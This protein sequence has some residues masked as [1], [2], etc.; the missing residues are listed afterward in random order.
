[1]QAFNPPPERQVQRLRLRW[2][3]AL[4]PPAELTWRSRAEDALRTASTAERSRVVFVRRLA[5][6]LPA[7]AA[8]PEAMAARAMHAPL[9][10]ALQAAVE[11]AVPAALADPGRAAA[12]WFADWDAALAHLLDHW[13]D[14]TGAAAAG[15]PVQPS[16]AATRTDW[17][18]AAIAR[19]LPGWLA[20]DDAAMAPGSAVAPRVAAVWC[21]WLHTPA[22][23]LAAAAW[24]LGRWRA[25]A[26]RQVPWLQQAH[27]RLGTPGPSAAAQRAGAAAVAPIVAMLQHM[28]AQR[29]PDWRVAVAG[30]A[31]SPPQPEV[32]QRATASGPGRPGLPAPRRA[33]LRFDADGNADDIDASAATPGPGGRP[34]PMPALGHDHSPAGGLARPS[35]DPASRTGLRRHG[36][37]AT[38]APR[39]SGDATRTPWSAEAPGWAASALMP[40][41]LGGLVLLLNL[42]QRLGFGGWLAAQPAARQRTLAMAPFQAVLAAAGRRGTVEPAWEEALATPPGDADSAAAG[43]AWLRRAGRAARAWGCGPLG[44]LLWRRAGIA[45]TPTHLDLVFRLDQVNLA[46]RRAALDADPGWV[47]W[48][49]RIVSLHFEPGDPWPEQWP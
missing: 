19:G 39:P 44:G 13:L 49:G 6:A 46:V 29:Q 31:W 21:A 23:A 3:S 40:T 33:R 9:E 43:R 15:D 4:P 11:R 28:I 5:L 10:Q 18:E 47:P 26:P 25:D 37:Q 36:A 8:R 14:G 22:S 17:V 48:F 2:P 24:A 35:V 27:R 34:R 45:L 1:M 41:Q 38:L 12:V 30:M 20:M 42:L 7:D 16:A 32:A